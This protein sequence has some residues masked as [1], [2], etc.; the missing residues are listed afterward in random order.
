MCADPPHPRR[1]RS[2]AGRVY[3]FLF[4][5]RFVV[6]ACMSSVRLAPGPGVPDGKMFVTRTRRPLRNFDL[7]SQKEEKGFRKLRI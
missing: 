5:R 2:R 6:S 7:Y 1:S 3:P 4:D